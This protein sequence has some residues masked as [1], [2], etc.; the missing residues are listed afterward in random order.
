MTPDDLQPQ[1]VT[2]LFEICQKNGKQIDIKYLRDGD[3]TIANVVVDGKFVASASSD[4]KDLARLEAAKIALP[5]LAHL[6]PSTNTK[7]NFYAEEDGTLVVEAAKQKLHEFCGGKKWPKP[8]YRYL[9]LF[10]DE[11]ILRIC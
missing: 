2:M 10:I 6:V 8:V 4:Q 7:L 11:D 9:S 3:R 5:K 1:P